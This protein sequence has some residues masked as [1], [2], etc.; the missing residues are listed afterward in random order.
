MTGR[1][2]AGRVKGV[3]IAAFLC[4][5]RRFTPPEVRVRGCR[6]GWDDQGSVPC[7]P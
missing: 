7:N 4:W 6:H 5:K 3:K 1:E 2:D